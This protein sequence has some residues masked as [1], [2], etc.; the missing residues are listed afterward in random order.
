MIRLD[1]T[2]IWQIWVKKSFSDFCWRVSAPERGRRL[3]IP[4]LIPSL[5]AFLR[6]LPAK[7]RIFFRK[8]TKKKK[9]RIFFFQIVSKLDFEFFH[10]NRKKK[11]ALG[12]PSDPDF[13]KNSRK[14]GFKCKFSR[15]FYVSPRKRALTFR[16]IGK[17]SCQASFGHFY[18]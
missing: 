3:E 17:K 2:H 13:T 6:F 14:I 11:L 8:V 5:T 7:N 15:F 9:N 12:W 16:K 4:S 10:Q 1:T 18:R